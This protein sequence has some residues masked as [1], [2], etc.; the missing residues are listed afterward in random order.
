MYWSQ[1]RASR[2]STNKSGERDILGTS[3]ETPEAAVIRNNRQDVR[4]ILYCISTPN[5]IY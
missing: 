5:T 2:G 3:Q 4:P 1:S